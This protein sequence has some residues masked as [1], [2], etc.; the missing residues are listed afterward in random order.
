MR[1]NAWKTP[2]ALGAATATRPWAATACSG[3]GCTGWPGCAAPASRS[4]RIGAG[5][6]KKPCRPPTPAAAPC[7]GPRSSVSCCSSS[8]SAGRPCAACRPSPT[9][10]S[11]WMRRG[12]CSA[13]D[14][15]HPHVDA[16]LGDRAVVIGDDLDL[17]HPGAL[18]ALD[19]R[20]DLLQ[21]GLHGILDTLAGGRR[22]FNHLG[23]GG[24]GHVLAPVTPPDSGPDHYTL[25]REAGCRGASIGA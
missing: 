22:H 21:P 18:D 8:G 9:G 2:T 7:R 19:G 16:P 5:S 13:D 1:W 20:G 4:C 15:T 10:R 11:H 25:A 3:G 17:V 14:E 12:A 23:N 6:R 24:T